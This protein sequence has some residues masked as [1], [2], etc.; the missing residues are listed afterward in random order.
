EALPLARRA[1]DRA[2]DE[3]A[4]RRAHLDRRTL[5]SEG[6]AGADARRRATEL[7]GD[8]PCRPEPAEVVQHRLD[9][10]DAAPARIGLDAADERERETDA[11]RA[12]EHRE[13]DARRSETARPADQGVPE[14][15]R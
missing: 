5:A 8:Q 10:R 11:H 6:E 9:V 13:R 14:Q 1:A 12:E 2:C 4:G 3:L 7:D 15:V